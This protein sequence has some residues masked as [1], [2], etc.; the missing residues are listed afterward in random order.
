LF[1]L[2]AL[3]ILRRFLDKQITLAL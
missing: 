1:I 2:T 3:S